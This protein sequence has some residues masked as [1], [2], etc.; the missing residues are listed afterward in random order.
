MIDA[1]IASDRV[2]SWIEESVV[3][4]ADIDQ[5]TAEQVISELREHPEVGVAVAGVVDEFIAALFTTD[6]DTTSIELTETLAPVVPLV[7]SELAAREV[8]V[9]EGVLNMALADVESFGLASG[10]LAVAV[11][12]VEDARSLLSLIVVLAALTLGV[13]GGLAVWLSED[14]PAMVRSLATRMVFSALSFTFLF[15]V[16]SWVLDPNGGGSPIARGGSVLLGSNADAFLL[17][18]IGAAL[19]SGGAGWTIWRRRQDAGVDGR[20]PGSDADTR[21]LVRI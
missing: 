10:D 20:G 5:A 2:Y 16:G 7:T 9:D 6:G 15:R 19:V 4:S 14:R 1:E 18:G 21:Q 12:V 11:R 13:A 17:I 3:S 8:P